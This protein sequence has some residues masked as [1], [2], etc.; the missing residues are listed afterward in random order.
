LLFIAACYMKSINM[1]YIA[2]S[3]QQVIAALYEPCRV[4]FIPLLVTREDYLDKATTLVALTY[5]FVTAVGTALGGFLVVTAGIRGCFCKYLR[6]PT[7][8]LQSY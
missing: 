6:R 1:I 3:L 8:L 4:S 7:N 5:S 2:T